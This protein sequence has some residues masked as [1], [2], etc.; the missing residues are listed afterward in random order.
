[1]R[2]GIG[3]D[4]HRL[5]PGGRLVLGGVEIPFGFGLVGHSDADVVIH[6]LMDSMLG[7]A[8]LP[9]IGTHFPPTEHEFRDISSLLLLERVNQ[10]V[11]SEG[12]RLINVDIVVVAEQPKIA[13]HILLMRKTVADTLAIEASRVGIKATTNEGVG[14]EGRMEA[15]SAHAVALLEEIP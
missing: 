15:I 3:Y 14:P 1:V 10:H 5:Q 4:I 2:V 9:D 7:A 12:L 8:G 6:A 11:E 13:P